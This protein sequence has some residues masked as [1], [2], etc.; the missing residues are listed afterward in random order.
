[1]PERYNPMKIHSYTKFLLTL[2]FFLLFTFSATALEV[3]LH[4][5]TLNDVIDYLRSTHHL[6]VISTQPTQRRIHFRAS[7]IALEPLLK[8]I[9]KQFDV[10]LTKKENTW[11]FGHEATGSVLLEVRRGSTESTLHLLKLQE[12]LTLLP[13]TASVEI[14][15][16]MVGQ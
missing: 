4:N 6:Q 9:A 11:M 1:M 12:P 2:T 10:P 3:N 13:G 7:H 5:A 14:T 15:P 8:Q 16:K